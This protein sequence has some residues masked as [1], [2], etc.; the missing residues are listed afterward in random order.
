MYM[1]HTLQELGRDIWMSKSMNVQHYGIFSLEQAAAML[2][3][4]CV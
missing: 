3:K 2:I 1:E 4:N